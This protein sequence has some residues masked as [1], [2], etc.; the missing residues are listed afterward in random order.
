[1]LHGFLLGWPCPRWVLV[2]LKFS[3]GWRRTNLL[4]LLPDIKQFRLLE[5]F[6]KW[7]LYNSS[8]MAFNFEFRERHM[9]SQVWYTWTSSV[10]N[11]RFAEDFQLFYTKLYKEIIFKL[12]LSGYKSI[13]SP[14]LCCRFLIFCE[15]LNRN[16]ENVPISLF[17]KAPDSLPPPPPPTSTFRGPTRVWVLFLNLIQMFDYNSI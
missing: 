9:Y 3:L 11:K 8:A 4:S 1:M 17:Y 2:L 16:E 14:N 5:R 13:M 15:F 10:T 7:Y 12:Q 6:R